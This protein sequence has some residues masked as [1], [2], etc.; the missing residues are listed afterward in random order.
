MELLIIKSGSDYI[1]VKKNRFV[2]CGLDKAS[3]FP[4]A[5]AEAVRALRDRLESE[6]VEKVSIKKLILTEQEWASDENRSEPPQKA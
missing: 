3:V 1:R 6:G 4:L 5:M 2:F